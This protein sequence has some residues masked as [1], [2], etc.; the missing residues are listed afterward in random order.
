MRSPLSSAKLSSGGS[1]G[2]HEVPV[3]PT[4]M[5]YHLH[6]W[7]DKWAHFDIFLFILNFNQENIRYLK[8]VLHQC[9]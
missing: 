3:L 6:V 4:E 7:W 8:I 5:K 2:G 1:F 9:Y